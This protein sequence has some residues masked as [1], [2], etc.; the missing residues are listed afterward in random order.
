M[1][2]VSPPSRRAKRLTCVHRGALSLQ[3]NIL[4]DLLRLGNYEVFESLV[5]G[6]DDVRDA[7]AVVPAQPLGDFG[8]QV[9]VVEAG[10]FLLADQVPDFVFG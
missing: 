7:L 4:E 6:H 5:L 3:R 10:H 8:D 2:A 1:S 9:V